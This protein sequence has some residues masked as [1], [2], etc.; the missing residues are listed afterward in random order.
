MHPFVLWYIIRIALICLD[1]CSLQNPYFPAARREIFAVRS[2]ISVFSLDTLDISVKHEIYESKIFMNNVARD[3]PFS[4]KKNEP[5]VTVNADLECSTWIR[6][7]SFVLFY[8][9]FFFEIEFKRYNKETK[10]VGMFSCCLVWF[11][12]GFPR[13]R[14]ECRVKIATPVIT[15]I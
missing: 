14:R 2:A 15:C 5:T 12:G 1:R 11:P 10:R 13:R 3:T 9:F 4:I 8:W 7:K 6:Q